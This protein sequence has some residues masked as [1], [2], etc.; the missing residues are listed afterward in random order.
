LKS[1]S[2]NLLETS[3]PVQACT[4]IAFYL[5]IC[6]V[7]DPKPEPDL[8]G[9]IKTSSKV[10]ASVSAERFYCLWSFLVY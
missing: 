3:R 1:R 10:I 8:S 5:R 2:L 6:D 7:L 9:S 4:E